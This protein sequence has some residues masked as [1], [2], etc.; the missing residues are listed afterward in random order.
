MR[1]PSIYIDENV[2]VPATSRCEKHHN[3]LTCPES[4]CIE[5]IRDRNNAN[6][7]FVK[8]RYIEIGKRGG[9]K[10]RNYTK[11]QW[12]IVLNRLH[13]IASKGGKNR[14]KKRHESE[15]NVQV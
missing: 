10:K 9:I 15:K 4:M 11:E 8:Q 7:E 3:C 5:D 14:W 13:E 6:P 2:T 1:T 12:D